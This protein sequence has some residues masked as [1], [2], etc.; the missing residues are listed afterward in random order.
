MKNLLKYYYLDLFENSI[1]IMLI[2]LLLDMVI[3]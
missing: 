2:L 1:L 3:R